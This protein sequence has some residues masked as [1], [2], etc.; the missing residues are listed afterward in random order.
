MLEDR[1]TLSSNRKRRAFHSNGPSGE[2]LAYKSTVL[3]SPSP[4][5]IFLSFFLDL[6]FL[7]GGRTTLPI[8]FPFPQGRALFT[9]LRL[10]PWHVPSVHATI[11]LVYRIDMFERGIGWR[12]EDLYGRMKGGSCLVG[13][14]EHYRY[15]GV[16]PHTAAPGSGYPLASCNL[17]FYRA[18][19]RL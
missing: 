3:S 13:I 2:S 4:S 18:T 12:G 17:V 11:H 19:G 8:K 1:A 10:L 5:S 7:H 15:D 9:G 14:T 16:Q 6:V